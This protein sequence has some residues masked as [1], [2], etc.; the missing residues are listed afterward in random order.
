MSYSV[1]LIYELMKL[2]GGMLSGNA[3]QQNIFHLIQTVI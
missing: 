1:V 2:P 3:N